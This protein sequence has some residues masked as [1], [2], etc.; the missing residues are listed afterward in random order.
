MYICI[1]DLILVGFSLP[2][3]ASYKALN[4]SQIPVDSVLCSGLIIQ[5]QNYGRGDVVV[6]SISPKSILETYSFKKLGPLVF[7]RHF[8]LWLY[9]FC[10]IDKPTKFNCY[11]IL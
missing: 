6:K 8:V 9:R 11:S 2:S 7:R 4:F 3:G 1:Y 10:N 5:Q